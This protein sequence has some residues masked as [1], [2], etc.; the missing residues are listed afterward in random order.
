MRDFRAEAEALRD[1]M[2]A[3]RRDLHQYPELGFEVVRTA[4]I[5][6]NWDSKSKRASEKQAWWAYWKAQ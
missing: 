3:R 2:V 5:V 6:A 1:E 4:G